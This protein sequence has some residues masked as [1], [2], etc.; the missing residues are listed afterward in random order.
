M[1]LGHVSLVGAGPGDPDLWTVKAARYV[2]DADVVFYDALVDA[3]ALRALTNAPCFCVGK[4]GGRRSVSQ[5]TIQRLMIR[6]ARRGQRVVRLKGGDPFVFG[7]GGE[8]ALALRVAGVPFDVVPGVSSAVAA[9]ASAGI[10]I[11]HRGLA[12][13]VLTVSGHDFG[14][15]ERAIGAIAP[16]GLTLVV[17]MGLAA[18]PAIVATLRQ[19]GWRA[20][21][22]AA[23]VCGATTPEAF[24]WTGTIAHLAQAELPAAPPGVIVIGEV[25]R[26]RD[27][28]GLE[29]FRLNA[30]ATLPAEAGSYV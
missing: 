10:P 25:V 26:L 23:I 13:A 12:S 11:T 19:R 20:D 4:R 8:E 27:A 22:P 16:N 29:G 9:P 5:E 1:S 17:L 6:A 24:T 21:T 15:F 30:E 18:R 3:R 14:V 28:I 7:R 2:R